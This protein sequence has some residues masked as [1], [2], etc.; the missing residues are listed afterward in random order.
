ML[1]HSAVEAMPLQ[2]LQAATET[3]ARQTH[4]EGLVEGLVVDDRPTS[5]TVNLTSTTQPMR[6]K[7]FKQNLPDRSAS[8]LFPMQRRLASVSDF[9]PASPGTP[10]LSPNPPKS[11]P[12]SPSTA[13]VP[14]VRPSPS[15]PALPANVP[16]DPELGIIRIQTPVPNPIGD[17]PSFAPPSQANCDSELGCLRLREPLPLLPL[18]LPRRSP[19]VY[20]LS[21]V[22]YFNSNNIFANPESFEGG[23]VKSGVTLYA[24]PALS[25][26]TYFVGSASGSL[27]RYTPQA[28]SNYTQLLRRAGILQ[29]SSPNYN[30]LLFR[31]GI[32]QRLSPVMFAE[33]G[34][35]NQQLFTLDDQVLSFLPGRR[36]F[37]E[38]VLRLELSRRDQLSP[39]LALNTFYQLRLS[40]AEPVERSRLS[41]LFSASLS[42][43][44]QPNLQAAL[45]YQIEL[46]DFTH[47]N[48]HDTYNQV[49]ARLTLT[50]FRNTQFTGF[51]GY[52]FGNS[53]DRQ[54]DFNAMFVGIN[55]SVSLGLF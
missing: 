36:L 18:P 16:A 23:L 31:A 24:V 44:L 27:V 20:W 8:V 48:R 29:R 37:N 52:G 3:D 46:S 2:P 32:L 41:N 5:T 11:S 35:S 45:D 1:L 43:N 9:D 39:R 13:P 21:R 19:S 28:Q 4:I 33:I 34:W 7:T 15:L 17:N 49:L 47:Q 50:A 6:L 30:E 55:V 54:I 51:I 38:N 14:S 53:S 40:F 26:N 10:D 12:N 25:K 22:D 42:Y